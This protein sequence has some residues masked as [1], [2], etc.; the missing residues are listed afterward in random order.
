MISKN[1]VIQI[2]GKREI[3]TEGLC[4]VGVVCGEANHGVWAPPDPV[5]CSEVCVLLSVGCPRNTDSMHSFRNCP[6][7]TDLI[8]RRHWGYRKK[9]LTLYQHHHPVFLKEAGVQRHKS[10]R[11]HNLS[12]LDTSAKERDDV[13]PAPHW[14][15]LEITL[16]EDPAK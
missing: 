5:Y 4:P 9:R 13:G 8:R 14:G 1:R 15:L 2:D 16:D 11:T 12:A 6:D 7:L 3:E 10:A